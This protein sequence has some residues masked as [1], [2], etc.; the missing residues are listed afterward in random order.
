MVQKS[1][2]CANVVCTG[3]VEIDLGLDLGFLGFPFDGRG[4]RH[5]DLLQSVARTGGLAACAVDRKTPRD[6]F[7]PVQP[8]VFTVQRSEILPL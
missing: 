3:P 6:V 8:L 4:S 5:A 1:N 7:L 2:T